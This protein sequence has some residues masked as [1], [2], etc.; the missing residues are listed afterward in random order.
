MPRA[1]LIVS[2]YRDVE[3]LAAI[4]HALSRQSERDFE[5]VISED[6]EDPAVAALLAR[7]GGAQLSHL[8]QPDCGFR[9]NR[10]LNRAI[11]AAQADH[12][13]FIDGD[14]LPQ[15]RFVE[16]HLAAADGHSAL[17]GR[18]VELGPHFSSH[19]R[20]DPTYLQRLDSPG[21][22]LRHAVGLHRDRVK[23]YEFGF[24]LPP[25]QPWLIGRPIRIVGSNF[26]APRAL[27][28]AV[29]GF[30]E[31]Y[32]SPGLGEDADLELRLRAAGF[33]VRNLKL[34]ACQYHLHH[35]RS[36]QVSDTNKALYRQTESSGAV[37]ALQ[38]LAEGG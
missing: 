6:G 28:E 15:R 32:T 14:C 2:V 34:S 25:L 26:S 13:I 7:Q 35:P 11:R 24:C 8:R 33:A 37:R 31:R 30:D 4:L 16:Q 17:A 29:N 27:L 38:G 23:N 19:L 5:V 9:K 22:W 21:R 18:R 1:S 12:L 10:A 36:Y 3:A 20:R